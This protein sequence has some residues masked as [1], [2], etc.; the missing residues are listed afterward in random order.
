MV[1]CVD[2][3]L[4]KGMC[5]RVS[6]GAHAW[7]VLRCSDVPM[8]LDLGVCA[9]ISLGTHLWHLCGGWA[10]CS[11]STYTRLGIVRETKKCAFSRNPGFGRG[12]GVGFRTVLLF[13][14]LV[15]WYK[16]RAG[17]P[18]LPSF[19]RV[20]HSGGLWNPGDDVTKLQ[21]P[22]K[23]SNA[24]KPPRYKAE[25]PASCSDQ[26][27]ET[28]V[29]FPRG[30]GRK[31]QGRGPRAREGLDV[32]GQEKGDRSQGKGLDSE[33]QGLGVGRQCSFSQEAA[34]GSLIACR[35]PRGQ[36]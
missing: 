3:G 34:S 29:R 31:V 20:E 25:V 14:N 11:P 5:I 13:S 7:H 32:Q 18:P 36:A 1:S 10:C 28:Q 27:A 19:S 17:K 22:G 35:R 12:R 6:L 30:W 23:M 2:M 9:H 4:G 16:A 26:G 33:G 8:S 21:T 15:T 24:Y